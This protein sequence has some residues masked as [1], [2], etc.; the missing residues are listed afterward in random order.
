[1]N[2]QPGDNSLPKDYLFLIFFLD[3][4]RFSRKT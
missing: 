4:A 2:H 1:M 3:F